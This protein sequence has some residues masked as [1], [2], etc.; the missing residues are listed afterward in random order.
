[1]RTARIPRK[2]A[3]HPRRSARHL[4]STLLLIALMPAAV[5][6]TGGAPVEAE[7]LR[8]AAG[9]LFGRVEVAVSV[10]SA[11]AV[12]EVVFFLDGRRV[13]AVREPPYRLAIDFGEENRP[14]RLRVLA[15]TAS[16]ATAEARLDAPAVRVDEEVDLELQQLY[17]SVT[18]RHG[19]RILDLPREGFTVVD[20]G[21]EQEIV[22]FEHGDL[23]LTAVLLM[24]S[25]FSM[26]GRQAEAA[27]DSVRSFYRGLHRLDEVRLL[28]FADRILEL[29]PFAAGP[30]PEPP[31]LEALEVRGGSAIVDHL[32]L[33]LHLLESRQGRRVV[34][35]LS[36]GADNHSAL[37]TEEVMEVALR[38][39]A[40]IYW[41]RLDEGPRR[42]GPTTPRTVWRDSREARAEHRA[43]ERTV[44]RSGGRIFTLR[45]IDEIE[46][47]Y[48]VILAELREQYALG[49]YPHPRRG[50]GAWRRVRVDVDRRGLEVRTREGYY[51]F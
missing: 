17:V 48:R 1:M 39:Q 11:E 9:P 41:V 2:S 51:D 25:S 47:A 13:G 34:V 24:D 29:T 43:L 36:D 40:L 6:A 8:P 50:D 23:P 18:D 26:K 15:R 5:L 4:L 3:R 14:H 27:R 35:L 49:Y 10:R 19:R 7:I 31:T 21:V 32:Y 30:S 38:S 28:V 45:R 12:E 37:A 22:T 33:A 42:R 20:E 16:G 46:P 44:R